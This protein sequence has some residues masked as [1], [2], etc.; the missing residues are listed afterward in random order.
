MSKTGNI[1][2]AVLVFFFAFIFCGLPFTSGSDS[3]SFGWVI[4]LV[5]ALALAVGS[6]FLFG[7]LQKRNLVQ[8]QKIADQVLGPVLPSG[9]SLLA[10]VH[11][12]TG[13]GRTGMILLFGALGDALIN[14]PRRKWYYLGITRQSLL[15]VQVNGKKPTG[16][17]QVLRRGEVQLAFESGALKEPRLTLQFAA[18]R[19]ELRVEAGM[20]TKAKEVAAAWLNS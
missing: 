16:V 8:Q 10:F 11:G 14:G 17:K 6:Y 19:M 20:V 13:P 7:A 9:E 1:L 12:Y 15:L 5:I 18:E 3:S 4:A 2:L